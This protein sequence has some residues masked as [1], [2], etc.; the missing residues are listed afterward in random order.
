MKKFFRDKGKKRKRREYIKV[1]G[2]VRTE[3]ERK[4]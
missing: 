4:A 2:F 3:T 1:N